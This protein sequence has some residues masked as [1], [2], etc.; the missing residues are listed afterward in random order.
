[1]SSNGYLERMVFYGFGYEKL[2]ILLGVHVAE[3]GRFEGFRGHARIRGL[4]ILV[5]GNNCCWV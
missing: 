5:M 3:L 1:M 2:Y 4:Y